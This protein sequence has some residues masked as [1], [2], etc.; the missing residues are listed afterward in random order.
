MQNRPKSFSLTYFSI[1][2]V[3]L[4]LVCNIAH[5]LQAAEASAS[6]KATLGVD[7]FMKNADRYRGKVSLEGAVAAVVPR[8]QAITLMDRGKMGVCSCVQVNLLPVQWRGPMPAMGDLIRVEG[9][10]QEVEGKLMFVADKLEKVG[11]P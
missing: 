7:E 6:S 1:L 11:H 10:A 5:S 4:L 3:T 9:Q 2:V 8:E